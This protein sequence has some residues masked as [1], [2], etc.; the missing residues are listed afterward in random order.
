LLKSGIRL[1]GPNQDH[2]GIPMSIRNGLTLLIVG[3][4]TL[5]VG[6]TFAL[7]LPKPIHISE[8][9]CN[10]IQPGMTQREVEVLVGA[11]PGDYE[12]GRRG[13]VLDLY[14]NGVLM[15]GGRLEQWGGDEGFIHVG[16]GPDGTVLW[17]RF[18]PAGRCLTVIDQGLGRSLH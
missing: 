3:V 1:S 18:V 8:A 13:I 2:C 7:L 15:N 6:V 11:P 14:G 4:T 5:F 12:T 9:I 17:K 10:D 16:F